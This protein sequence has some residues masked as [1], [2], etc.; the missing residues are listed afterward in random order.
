M[1]GSE[2][3]EVTVHEN[4][5]LGP[6]SDDLKEPQK[7]SKRKRLREVPAKN[8]DKAESNLRTQ[9]EEPVQEEQNPLH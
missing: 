1:K 4:K 8:G 2:K 3:N 7:Q 5:V 9:A 6:P